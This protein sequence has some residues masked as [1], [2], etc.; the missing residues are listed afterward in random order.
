MPRPLIEIRRYLAEL[1][2]ST[3][4]GWNRFFFAPADPTA[5]GLIRA[6]VGLLAF[7]SLLVMGLDL[8]AYLGSGGW[9]SAE[10]AWSSLRPFAWSF[11]FLVGDAWLRPAWIG[12]LV[13]LLFF[14][15]GIF[16]RTTSVL[17]WMI[18]VSTVRRAPAA[19][20]GFDQIVS[21]LLLYLAAT[22][23]SGQAFALDRYWRRWRE[24]KRTIRAIPARY[25]KDGLGR[26]VEPDTPGL[27]A[28]TVSANLALRLIQ[29]HLVMIYAIAGLAKLQGVS[30]WNGEAVWR[31]MATGEFV[32]FDFTPLARWPMA[33]SALTHGS[34]AL[35]LVYPA[36]IWPRLTRPIMLTG[37]ACLHVGIAVVNP[38][39]SEFALVMIAANLAFVPGLYVRRLA[40][41]HEQPAVRV[42]FDGACPRCRGWM[43]LL[44]AADPCHVLA[45]VDLTAVDVRTVH[46]ALTEAGCLKAMHAVTASG[47]VTAGFDALRAI[48]LRL[49]LFWPVALLG[50][51]PGVAWA[52]RI[53]YNRYAASRPRDV[54][55]TDS[56]C[57]IH[58]RTSPPAARD[59]SR[60]HAP[61]NA[62]AIQEDS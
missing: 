31:M 61:N 39:L 55:C 40:I 42:L 1:S 18:V 34:L 62:T 14:T 10:L 35:E 44:T 50:Y 43:A 9:E 57:G 48:L 49:P 37:V 53:G 16:S 25:R 45:A 8:D 33:L 58:S 47:R 12:C 60:S 15:L 21:M 24:A 22:G 20:F 29:I 51:F 17:S 52:G 5:L 38:G 4:A 26:A 6:A 36:L 2:V 3:R 23:A 11:W 32:M 59:R 13:V 19:L 27:P 30:W 7:W 46:P 28:A 56:V 54:P 41:A